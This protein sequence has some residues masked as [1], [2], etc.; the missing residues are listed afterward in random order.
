MSQ[1]FQNSTAR[2]V[3]GDAVDV[4]LRAVAPLAGGRPYLPSTEIMPVPDAEFRFPVVQN[5]WVVPDI[6]SA[7]KAWLDLGVG[8]FLVFDVAAPDALYRGTPAPLAMTIALA[9][10]GP[11][12]IELI[13]QTSPGPS[14]YRDVVP[15][16]GFGFH[17]VCRAI[18]GYDENRA[19]LVSAG[20]AVSTEFT[21]GGSRA[22]YIDTRSSL[23]CMLE[24]VDE[25]DIATR[26][27]NTVREMAQG[28]DGRDPF[29]S[30]NL[31]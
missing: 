30:M 19:R 26:L 13:R 28:W 16:G 2:R 21:V 12:Q 23:G 5:C 24:L 3:H 1:L 4:R 29:R 31:L 18:G 14:A 20:A 27:N 8:P 10:A 25:S 15:E 11:V 9:Q 6:E 22:C 17:H 7:A